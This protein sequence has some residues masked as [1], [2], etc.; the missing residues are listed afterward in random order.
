MTILRTLQ[1]LFAMV[2]LCISI[3]SIDEHN[4]NND[5]DL[6]KVPA[7]L[8]FVAGVGGLTIIAAVASFVLFLTE[9]LRGYFAAVLDV[10]ILLVNLVGGVVSTT[11][12]AS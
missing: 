9:Y 11:A 2:V 5:T 8:P 6:S 7:L 12:K 3:I 4:P 1:G 10:I